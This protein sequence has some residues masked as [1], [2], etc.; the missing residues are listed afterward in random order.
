MLW[1]NLLVHSWLLIIAAV[2]TAMEGTFPWEQDGCAL[3]KN[4]SKAALS[5]EDVEGL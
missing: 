5:D 4:I 3:G 2:A 1:I